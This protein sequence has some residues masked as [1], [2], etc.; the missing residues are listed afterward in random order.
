MSRSDRAALVIGVVSVVAGLRHFVRLREAVNLVTVPAAAVIVFAALGLLAI[1]AAVMRLRPLVI[2]AGAGYLVAALAWLVI[3]PGSP[4]WLG[5][6]GSTFA[7]L[8]GLGIGL[9]ALG[10]APRESATLTGRNHRDE[11]DRAA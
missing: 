8:S 11:P 9:L 2:A 7:L 6:D 3:T 5:A 10:L 4:N 1:A